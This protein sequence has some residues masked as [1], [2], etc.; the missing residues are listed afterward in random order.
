MLAKRSGVS[1][2]TIKRIE[3]SIGFVMSNTPTLKALFSAFSEAGIVFVGGGVDFRMKR[4]GDRV[5]GPGR[6]IGTVIET[7]TEGGV[8]ADGYPKI[9]VRYPDRETD[10]L[11]QHSVSFEPVEGADFGDNPSGD[12][13][14]S[15]NSL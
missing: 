8:D 2:A 5:I 4:V 3:A 13:R 1:V 15:A 11:L 10:W 6:E 14:P 7:E 12:S 9:R